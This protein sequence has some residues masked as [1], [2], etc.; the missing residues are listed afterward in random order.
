M[1]NF[2]S[3]AGSVLTIMEFVF[4][5]LAVSYTMDTL[6]EEKR[7]FALELEL[8]RGDYQELRRIDEVECTDQ[9]CL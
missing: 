5:G 7:N 8:L 1:T 2:Y 4:L 9:K 3:Y 6:R